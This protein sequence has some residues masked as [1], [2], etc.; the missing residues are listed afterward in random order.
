MNEKVKVIGKKAL[1]AVAFIAIV[2]YVVYAIFHFNRERDNSLCMG[3]EVAIMDSSEIQFIQS[4]DVINV[5]KGMEPE[6]AGK[7]MSRL[8]TTD[9]ERT[10][11]KK[12]I[13]IKDVEVYKT[14][15]SKLQVNIWQR[16]P[17]LRV[18]NNT[19]YDRYIDND[20]KSMP[21]PNLEPAY[22][23][24]AN[25]YISDTFATNTLY[26]FAKF[27][28]S[29]KFWNAQIEQIY[30]KHNQEVIL[31]PRVGGHTIEM[32]KL[33]NYEEK[34]NKLEKVYTNA[35][36]EKGWDNYSTINLKFDQQVVCTKK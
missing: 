31:V 19:G 22:V 24:V 11:V 5:I 34:L 3:I 26:K 8:N 2:V 17:V 13:A 27:L 23:P 20:G 9:I 29:D 6:L 1:T 16:H 12:L 15:S 14:P 7:N 28:K 21:I 4:S 25:G 18:I 10:L 36:P 30:V 33:T 35:F 32:G